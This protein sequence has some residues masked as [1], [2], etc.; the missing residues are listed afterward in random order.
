[1]DDAET[2]EVAAAIWGAYIASPIVQ[3]GSRDV[4]WEMLTRW[5]AQRGPESAPGLIRATALAEARAA[6]AIIRRG[7]A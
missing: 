1:M 6:I 3:E 2:E 4:P 7:A 5:A